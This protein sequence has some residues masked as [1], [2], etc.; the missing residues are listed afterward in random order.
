MPR[1]TQYNENRKLDVIYTRLRLGVN[2][3]K[4]NNMFYGM[5]NPICDFC[6]DEIK[7]TDHYLLYCPQHH[8]ER[9]TSVK[10]VNITS[11]HLCR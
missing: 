8:D 6:K 4:A 1:I 2:G 10:Y 5:A 7:D 11:L 3:L 9:E